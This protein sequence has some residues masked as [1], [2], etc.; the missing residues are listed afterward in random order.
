MTLTVGVVGCGNVGPN[1]HIPN[2]HTHPNARLGAVC[3]ADGER[4]TD[5]AEANEV[6]GY[7]DIEAML[8]AES[9]DAVHL[10][11][12][13]QTHVSLG[14]TILTAGVPMLM[15]KPA[16]MNAEEVETLIEVQ[17]QTGTPASVVHSRLY[18]P[19]IR[20]ARRRVAQGE[21][22]ETVAVELSYSRDLALDETIRGDW[23]FEFPGASIGEGLPHQIYV[24]LAFVGPLA[25]ISCVTT[26]SRGDHETT[27]FD[28][29][30]IDA[31]S[32]D[33]ALIAITRLTDGTT[34]DTIRV[35][36][37]TGTI[38]VDVIQNAVYTSRTTG[39]AGAGNLVSEYVE[40][41]TQLASNFLGNGLAFAKRTLYRQLDDPR[42]SA[43]TPHY[44]LFDDFYDALQAGTEPPVTL[45][46][47]RDSMRVIDAVSAAT[48]T[49]EE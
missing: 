45:A 23:I 18:I 40:G 38:S 6:P 8:Q 43:A 16:A 30:T 41:A 21:I 29:L 22:G 49:P 9:L 25:E 2:I 14:E 31:I 13:P 4:V 7:T 5:V 32:E 28:G 1:R 27:S 24:P 3:D 44:A 20:R 47:A 12:P 48:A 17:E 34:D 11:T 36:G 37:T 26:R 19:A 35:Y 42:G 46:D 39:G 33:D 10:C 15:E